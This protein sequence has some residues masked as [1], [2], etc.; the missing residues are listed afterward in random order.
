MTNELIRRYLLHVLPKGLMRVRHY[1]FVAN[2]C[3]RQHLHDIR[4]VLGA[5]TPTD[6]LHSRSAGT[7]GGAQAQPAIEREC[8]ACRQGHL[9]ARY[10]IDPYR[11]TEG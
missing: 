7:L 6:A 3:R 2:H 11:L 1:G 8:P 10:R 4:K 9:I 5:N